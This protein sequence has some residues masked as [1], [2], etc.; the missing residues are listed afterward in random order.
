VPF[1]HRLEQQS[2][3]PF[4]H[5]LPAVLHVVLSGLQL[6]FTHIVLQHSAPPAVHACP[7]EMHCVAPQTWFAQSSVQQSVC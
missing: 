5:A 1:V 7:S 4:G 2:A 3:L 6:P